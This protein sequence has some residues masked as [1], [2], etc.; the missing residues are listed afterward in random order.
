M[1]PFAAHRVDG[2]KTDVGFVGTHALHRF[3]GLFEDAPFNFQ[4]QLR[5]QPTRQIGR[6]A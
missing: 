3:V 6:D 5:G 4:A 2:K 1:Q